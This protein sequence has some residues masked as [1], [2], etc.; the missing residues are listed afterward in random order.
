MII[1]TYPHYVYSYPYSDRPSLPVHAI[2]RTAPPLP[3]GVQLICCDC[4]TTHDKGCHGGD[5]LVAYEYIVAQ[6]TGWPVCVCWPVC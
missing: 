6:G 4:R 1:R 5:P 2:P 3:P